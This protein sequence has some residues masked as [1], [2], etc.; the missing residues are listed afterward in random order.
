[1]KR[2][3]YCT[4]IRSAFLE[5]GT[6]NSKTEA[7][8]TQSSRL[9]S[10]FV[11]T[12]FEKLAPVYLPAYYSQQHNTCTTDKLQAEAG[13][14]ELQRGRKQNM[15][16]FNSLVSHL[17]YKASLNSD[18]HHWATLSNDLFCHSPKP[19]DVQLTIINHREKKESSTFDTVNMWLWFLLIFNKSIIETVVDSFSIY[20][21][22][23]YSTDC[24]APIWMSQ[25]HF[26][27][28]LWKQRW[29]KTQTMIIS[30][31]D[32]NVCVL[33]FCLFHSS[34]NNFSLS[35]LSLLLLHCVP[36][37][38]GHPNTSPMCDYYIPY[39][40]LYTLFQAMAIF[41][42]NTFPLIS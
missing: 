30:A 9:D 32:T 1:M 39:Y 35:S 6:Q 8:S 11:K 3:H 20:W 18:T 26:C 14:G 41:Q 19:K 28:L 24:L 40:L 16:T 37:V 12:S 36:N 17:F 31:T 5:P 15:W 13:F 2:P 10:E 23:N 29:R 25:F 21:L 34:C 38:C 42:L 33:Y 4:G 27:R 7:K 22:I